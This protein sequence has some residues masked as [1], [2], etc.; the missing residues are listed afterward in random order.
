MITVG[1][2]E[3][4]NTGEFGWNQTKLNL[5][6]PNTCVNIVAQ[7]FNYTDNVV[8]DIEELALVASY[9]DLSQEIIVIY[10]M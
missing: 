2:A 5:C 7:N 10:I 3:G 9:G 6:F 8:F 1:E 4:D